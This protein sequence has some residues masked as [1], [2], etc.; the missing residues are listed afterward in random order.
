MAAGVDERVE[1]VTELGLSR[2]ALKKLQIVD[3][4]HVDGPQRILESQGILRPQRRHEAVH[5]LLGGQIEHLALGARVAG[6]SQ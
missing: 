2:S 1:R 5:E 4:E 3:D 6:P